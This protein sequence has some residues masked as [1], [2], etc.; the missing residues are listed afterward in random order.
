M[1]QACSNSKGMNGLKEEFSK[2][3]HN[4]VDDYQLFVSLLTEILVNMESAVNEI[5]VLMNDSYSR[6]QNDTKL[7]QKCVSLAI[8]HNNNK[9]NN[10]NNNRI[11]GTNGLSNN[12]TRRLPTNSM[13]MDMLAPSIRKLGS[14]RMPSM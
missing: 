8:K 14:L 13:S 12:K 3:S 1:R 2:A 7:H 5:T 10:N 4:C 11:N 6:F 9:N